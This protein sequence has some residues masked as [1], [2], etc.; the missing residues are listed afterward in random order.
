MT[1]IFRGPFSWRILWGYFNPHFYLWIFKYHFDG[2]FSPVIFAADII[3]APAGQAGSHRTGI[4][5]SFPFSEKSERTTAW[6][7]GTW[8]MVQSRM[9]HYTPP[10]G[11]GV[12]CTNVPCWYIPWYIVPIVYQVAVLGIFCSFRN[13]Q[14]FPVRCARASMLAP[15]NLFDNI[16]SPLR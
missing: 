3:T 7:I 15:A 2:L 9:V 5:R 14:I 6:Y 11:G 8:Y 13:R 10:K 16:K 4:F 1:P 12:Y